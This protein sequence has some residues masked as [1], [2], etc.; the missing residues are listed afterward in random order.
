MGDAAKLDDR[1]RL[2]F[3]RII[4]ASLVMAAVTYGAA[5]V[6]NTAL[7]TSGLRYFALTVLV[8]IG[9][10]S[11]GAAA[12][13]FKATSLSDLKASLKRLKR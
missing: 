11:Y 6:L 5:Y 12:L 2:R 4:A 3:P 8:L 13:A 7:H 9:A 1:L 10:I